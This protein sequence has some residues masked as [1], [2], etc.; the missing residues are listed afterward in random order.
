MWF[1]VGLISFLCALYQFI[2][3]ET[4]VAN[5]G[6][7]SIARFAFYCTAAVLF[8][9]VLVFI[10]LTNYCNTAFEMIGKHFL[11]KSV[12]DFLIMSAECFL[13]KLK[14]SGVDSGEVFALFYRSICT[15][16][17][18][19]APAAAPY[20]PMTPFSSEIAD[21]LVCVFLTVTALSLI[22]ILSPGHHYSIFEV[23]TTLTMHLSME[24][25]YSHPYIS[26]A[27]TS[28]V[29]LIIFLKNFLS[30]KEEERH[31]REGASDA[32]EVNL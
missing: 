22:H 13:L 7:A 16:G 5:V 17:D 29:F 27:T 15:N 25:L 12:G 31:G 3:S 6:C 11:L 1:S 2:R 10:L 9:A 28:F 30:P 8:T 14:N 18:S 21:L 23:T 24:L 19:M 32:T 20:A 26:A 4:G